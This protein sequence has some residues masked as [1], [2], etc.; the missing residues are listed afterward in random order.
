M[1]AGVAAGGLSDA[2]NCVKAD[3]FPLFRLSQIDAPSTHNPATA[4]P[5]G[6]INE[7]RRRGDEDSGMKRR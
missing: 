3:S 5:S 1:I 2:T 6:L 7:R 4:R